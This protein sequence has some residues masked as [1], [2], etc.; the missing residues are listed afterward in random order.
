M[1]ELNFKN[2]LS[3]PVDSLSINPNFLVLLWTAGQAQ[4]RAA[5]GTKQTESKSGMWRTRTN[6][7]ES[8]RID[9]D[10]RRGDFGEI[11]SQATC[12]AMQGTEGKGG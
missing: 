8:D 1:G 10:C 6:R 11:G 7:G 4:A 3:H 12:P 2:G 5:G 9:G